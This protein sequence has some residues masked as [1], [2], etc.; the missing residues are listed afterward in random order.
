[1]N[2]RQLSIGFITCHFPPDSIGGGQ[3]QSYRLCNALGRKNTVTVY[4]RD[5][6]G[7]ATSIDTIENFNAHRRPVINIPVIRSIV[8]L[9]RGM[10]T[11]Y[12]SRSKTDVYLSFHI[13]LAALI[14]VLSKIVWGVVG[15]VSPRGE[16]DFDFR[17]F[18]KPFQKFIYR[19]VSAILIQSEN[20]RD[21]FVKNIKSVFEYNES[22]EIIKKIFIFPNGINSV[23]GTFAIDFKNEVSIIYV[24][25]LIDYKGVEYLIRAVSDIRMP[26]KLTIVGN[27]PHRVYLEGISPD[28]NIMF[29]GEKKFQEVEQYIR[30]SHVL[31]LPSLTENLPNVILEALAFGVPVIATN[32]G[33]IP[34][35]IKD[36]V[37]GYIVN[38]QSSKEISQAILNMFSSPRS[39]EIMRM[40]AQKSVQAYTWDALL[41]QLQ[42]TLAIIAGHHA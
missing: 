11:I 21:K 24:G 14:V 5:Y 4:L 8:D 2:P 22:S 35:I 9:I 34:E 27:G 40:E 30:K 29:L 23:E 1:M 6:S 7:L 18:K 13:Q 3:V 15:T 33:A 28:K 39:Y 37:N 41:P 17:G 38:P 12:Y 42:D 16:E 25:R 36:S 10:K 32:V 20:I 31:V 19:N 26:Y